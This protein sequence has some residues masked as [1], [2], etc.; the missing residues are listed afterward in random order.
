MSAGG[1]GVSGFAALDRQLAKMEKGFGGNAM[2]DALFR[3]GTVIAE[4]AKRLV[5]VRTGNLRD[6]IIVSF[7]PGNFARVD[8]TAIGMSV[9]VGPAQGKSAPHDGFYGHMVEFGTVHSA[10][11]PFM[12]PALASKGREA[13]GI[14]RSELLSQLGMMMR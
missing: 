5:P 14:I 1:F 7:D 2:R 8:G 12:R 10:A 4:E 3:A 9:Y 6:S 13:E 11:H